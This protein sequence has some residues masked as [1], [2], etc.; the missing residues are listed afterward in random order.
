M[1]KLGIIYLLLTFFNSS[2]QIDYDKIIL[3]EEIIKYAELEEKLVQL[4]WK[5]HPSS[6]IVRTNLDIADQNVKMAS[7]SWAKDVRAQF[8]IN[9][10]NIDPPEDR[11]LFFP[12]YNFQVNL[13][14]G[15]FLLTSKEVKLAKEDYKLAQSQVNQQKLQLRRDVL[16]KYQKYLMTKNLFQIENEIT[17]EEYAKYLLAEQQFKDGTISIDL[18]NES[19]RAYNTQ[20][21]KKITAENNFVTAKLDVEEMIGMHIEDVK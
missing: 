18:Y 6:K 8:N 20:R 13:S 14:L 4:A 1:K 3:P 5:N 16:T 15:T 9:E 12:R 19:L 2:A 17:E 21:M 7:F 11:P 10:G